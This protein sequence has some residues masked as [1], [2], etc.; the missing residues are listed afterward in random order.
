MRTEEY[1]AKDRELKK[2]IRLERKSKGLCPRCGGERDDLNKAYCF[3]CREYMADR[4]AKYLMLGICPICGKER[5]YG[6]EKMCIDCAEIT[7]QRQ[8]NSREK[9]ISEE[10]RENK[11][12][13]GRKLIENRKIQGLCPRC[14]KR[15]MT[16]GFQTCTFCRYKS[17]ERARERR[18]RT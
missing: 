6:D 12:I 10:A 11:R 15:K 14:G 7:R 17:T 2:N 18:A 1:K 3:A 13:Y 8:K 5:I 9:N 16:V 4:R